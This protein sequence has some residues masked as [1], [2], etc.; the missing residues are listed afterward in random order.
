MTRTA[1]MLMILA[2]VPMGFGLYLIKSKSFGKALG[3]RNLNG[4]TTA[5]SLSVGLY[6][7]FRVSFML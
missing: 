6:G 7:A 1:L 2:P 5:S 3:A 4:R